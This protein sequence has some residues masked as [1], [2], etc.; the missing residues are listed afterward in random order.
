MLYD[1]HK[2]QNDKKPATV[3][4]TYLICGTKQMRNDHNG[5]VDMTN[6]QM[7]EDNCQ[8]PFSDEVPMETLSLVKEE[9][10][11]SEQA[12]SNS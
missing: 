12:V 1:F 9:Q 2:W 6:S 10:L 5:D 4:A 8:T 7:S 3:H 11:E